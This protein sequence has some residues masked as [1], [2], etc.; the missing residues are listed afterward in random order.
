M[1]KPFSIEPGRLVIFN[2]L[3]GTVL[4]RFRYS[5]TPGHRGHNTEGNFY[6]VGFPSNVVRVCF[7]G[8]LSPVPSPLEVQK[9]A[10]AHNER[11]CADEA[12]RL[13]KQF[14]ITLERM[15]DDDFGP[16]NWVF[17]PSDVFTSGDDL[18]PPDPFEDSHAAFNWAETLFKVETYAKLL[19][20]LGHA[21]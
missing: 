16:E 13:A 21:K 7:E 3:E 6:V 12:N 4:H 11:L 2:A 19:K 15:H 20:E 17:P 10:E 18:L 9:A 5:Q 14:G 8:H 1:T